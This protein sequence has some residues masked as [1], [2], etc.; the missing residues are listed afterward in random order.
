MDQE[1]KARW[2]KEEGEW[3]GEEE[4]EWGYGEYDYETPEFLEGGGDY[5]HDHL[6][7]DE[8]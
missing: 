3:E 2:W 4:G 8:L 6:P 7:H 1:W 5:P